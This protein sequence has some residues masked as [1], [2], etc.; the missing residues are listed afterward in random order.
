[1]T[2]ASGDEGESD[3]R[4]LD[5]IPQAGEI[6]PEFKPEPAA[7]VWPHGAYD[8]NG[9]VMA[10]RA[11]GRG[12]DEIAAYLR[13]MIEVA[14]EMQ[15]EPPE[16]DG[17][18]VVRLGAGRAARRAAPEVKPEGRD[19]GSKAAVVLDLR[20][21]LD[22]AQRLVERDHTLGGVPTLHH[23]RDSWVCWDGRSSY[24]ILGERA[25]RTWLYQALARSYQAG[26]GHL[27][28]VKPKRGMVNDII[29]ALKAACALDDRIEPPAWLGPVVED[30][31]AAHEFAA[32]R[33]GLV[34]LPSRDLWPPDPS[35]FA[36]GAAGID[37]DP[38]APEPAEWLAFL[39]SLWPDD[40]ASIDTLQEII[41]YLISAETAQQK[42]FFL[43]GVT[44]SGKGTIGR[45][46]TK[47]LGAGQVAAPGLGDFGTRFG[48]EGLVGKAVAI[49]A[50]ARLSK[51][52]D[53]API[54]EKMLSISGEDA[55]T[56]DRKY[57][58]PCAA[59]WARDWCSCQTKYRN[60]ETRPAPSRTASS[61]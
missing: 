61:F 26:K 23:W 50:D 57:T 20:G 34:H 4:K 5:E 19:A 29:D 35:F 46:V 54:I 59:A 51:R 47:L 52:A 27:E 11:A 42:I 41:G 13:R 55:I 10:A 1:M 25:V 15:P 21:P 7:A 53:Q 44:R 18:K 60:F 24:E 49:I 58:A 9:F 17:N 8:V 6:A 36:L 2:T 22:A 28:R 40:Q 31:P 30:R 16:R 39:R 38:E 3:A 56:I 45:V 32:V 14:P 33:N 12:Q 37:C 48:L 43:H